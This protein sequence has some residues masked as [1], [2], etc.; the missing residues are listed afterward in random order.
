MIYAD[1]SVVVSAFLADVHT[2]RVL[3]WLAAAREATTLSIWT[4]TEFSSAAARQERMSRI[5]RDARLEA[6]R[7]FDAWLSA[8]EPAPV[9]RGDFEYAR[10]LLRLGPTRL[11]AAD[12]LHVAVARRLG[13]RLA[14]LDAAMAEAALS[15]GLTF[16]PI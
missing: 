7:N 10:D 11:R 12:A 5:T 14:T 6:E 8:V 9:L 13:A 15:A 1:S 4:V 16:E 2:P 3:A